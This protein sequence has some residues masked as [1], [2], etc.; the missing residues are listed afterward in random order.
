MQNWNENES[1]MKEMKTFTLDEVRELLREQR[2]ICA[3]V[4]QSYRFN[5]AYVL[6]KQAPEPELG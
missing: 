6:I 5:K 3:K 2:N 4:A 1:R